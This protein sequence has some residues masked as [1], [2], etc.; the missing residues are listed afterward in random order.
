MARVFLLP[1]LAATLA[2]FP[3][4][5]DSP[6]SLREA[7]AGFQTKLL[8]KESRG[9]APEPPPPG[10][11]DLVRYPAPLGANAAYVSPR[12]A[13]GKKHPAVIWLVGGFSNSIGG[14]AWTPGP[15]SNDQSAS[16][17]RDHGILMLYPSLRGGNNNPGHIETFYGEV[18]DVLAAADYLASLDYVDPARIYLGGHSTGGTLALLAAAAAPEGR[19]RSVFALGPVEDVIG[20]GADVLP[21]DLGDPK[22][23]RLRAPQ[24]W[25]ADIQC[26]TFVFEGTEQ[27]GNFSSL[28]ALQKRSKN[29]RIQ[30]VPVPGGTHFSIIAPTVEKLSRHILS[31]M[32]TPA[33]PQASDALK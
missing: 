17:F 21:F 24:N 13:D 23:G 28:Q 27:P 18:D 3:A 5:T 1:L 15:A 30:F 25:L 14:F 9:E 26:P 32:E 6:A 11:L 8:R 33:A 2:C 4:C 29:R 31:D 12:P 16:A 19:F 22:E 7:R 20:Y 10:V